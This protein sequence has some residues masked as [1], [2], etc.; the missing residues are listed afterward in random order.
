MNGPDHYHAAENLLRM[1][2]IDGDQLVAETN[3]EPDEALTAAQVHATLAL[4]AATALG[5][6]LF[7]VNTEAGG[8][9]RE[10]SDWYAAVTP[11]ADPPANISKERHL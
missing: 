8:L 1:A 2:T 7:E 10:A 5:A 3:L 11:A 6:W 4:T 9:S